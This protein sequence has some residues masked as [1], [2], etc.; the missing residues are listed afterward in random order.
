MWDRAAV[1]ANYLLV[2]VGIVGTIAAICTLKKIERQTKA[3]E[4]AAKAA[5]LQAEHTV[6][7]ERGWLSTETDMENF[8]PTANSS[9]FYWKVVNTGKSVVKLISTDARCLVWNGYDPLPDT[10]PLGDT[11]IKLNGRILAPGEHYQFKGRF[12]DWQQGAYSLH[13]INNKF[14]S[15]NTLYLLAYGKVRYQTFGKD[16]ESNF[17]EDYTWIR[18][19]PIPVNGFRPK[20][21]APSAYSDHT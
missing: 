1:I 18:G 10:P 2:L 4:D 17:V 8:N 14:D 15:R 13:D 19:E 12:E 11:E 6:A 9:Q 20:L 21:E 3:G 16:C 7:S 5:R